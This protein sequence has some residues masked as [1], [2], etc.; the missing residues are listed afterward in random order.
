MKDFGESSPDNLS[1]D[2]FTDQV[3][4]LMP[5]IMLGVLQRERNDLATGVLTIPQL[6]VL[7]YLQSNGPSMMHAIAAQLNLKPSNLTGIVD[8]LVN[9]GMVRRDNSAQDRRVVMA[10]MTEQGQTVLERI[11]Q[12]KRPTIKRLYSYLTPYERVVYV[13]ILSK[14]LQA[15]EAAALPTPETEMES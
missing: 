14:V 8:R 9:M 12:E 10:E 5:R 13:K 1:E 11:L 7:H 4:A 15:M 3:A 2:D 6:S